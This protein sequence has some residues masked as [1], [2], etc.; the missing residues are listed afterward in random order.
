MPRSFC[1]QLGLSDPVLCVRVASSTRLIGIDGSGVQTWAVDTEQGK[2]AKGSLWC[3]PVDVPA[4][5]FKRC[6]PNLFRTLVSA[7]PQ[8]ALLRDPSRDH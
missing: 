3:R 5:T 1:A 7:A 4:V 6:D 2:K 8:H